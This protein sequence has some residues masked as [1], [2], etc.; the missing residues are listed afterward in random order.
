MAR[1]K[2]KKTYE[3]EELNIEEK[4]EGKDKLEKKHADDDE[5]EIKL[6]FF[7]KK[8]SSDSSRKKHDSDDEFIEFDFDKLSSLVSANKKLL[9]FLT[10]SSIFLFAL[11]TRLLP[12]TSGMLH[13]YDPYFWYRYAKL[14][15]QNGLHFPS[16][17]PYSYYPPGR[18]FETSTWFPA[19]QA[20]LYLFLK[21]LIPSITLMQTAKLLPA[22]YGSL[23]VI[24]AYFIGKKV[25]SEYAG[26]FSAFLIG[27]SPAIFG[28][29]LA[30]FGDTDGVV[31]FYSLLVIAFY[32]YM[33]ESLENK[34]ITKTT[35][36]YFAA[37][38]IA[39]VIFSMNWQMAVYITY[40]LFTF[41]FGLMLFY[42][43]F[44][45][46]KNFKRV[47]DSMKKAKNVTLLT[48]GFILSN[49]L[50]V[51]IIKFGLIP[52]FKGFLSNIRALLITMSSYSNTVTGLKGEGAGVGAYN[53]FISVAEMQA[54]Q[55]S[56]Y[57]SQLGN[58]MYLALFLFTIGTALIAF[59]FSRKE[60]SEMA[61]YAVTGI[62]L[63]LA[64][65][66]YASEILISILLVKLLIPLAAIF[67]MISLS[68]KQDFLIN[69]SNVFFEDERHLRGMLLILMW[70]GLLFAISTLGIRF[71]MVLSPAICVAAGVFIDKIIKVSEKLSKQL[72]PI[73]LLIFAIFIVATYAPIAINIGNSSGPSMTSE[74]HDSLTWIKEN[75]PQE[76]TTISWWDPGHWV[77]AITQRYSGADGA[78]CMG[79]LRPISN[80]IDDFGYMFATTNE[81]ES[82]ERMS[83]YK[84][85]ASELYLIS[86]ADLMGKFTW[87]SFF[88]SGQSQN[89]IMLNKNGEQPAENSTFHIYP[90]NPQTALIVSQEENGMMRPFLAEGNN[91]QP[92]REIAFVSENQ[93]MRADLQEGLEAMVWVAPNFGQVIF[94]PG[95]LKDNILTRTLLFQGQG[96]EHFELVYQTPQ[97][98]LYRI[99]L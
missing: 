84:G 18:V 8:K 3:G 92:I 5:F 91:L 97:I 27:T 49:Y 82:L 54:P 85:N 9:V 11:W 38:V 86:S 57:T 88:S 41:P 23:S 4:H 89:Y 74:W 13:A 78:H 64:I 73:V 98:K 12:G 10:L 67:F 76:T 87:L 30:G 63:A 31:V 29:T 47:T 62:F 90:I 35:W 39:S 45:Q 1:K 65:A 53:V 46:G 60:D 79:C 52:G 61:G 15:L 14:F 17:D 20:V 33:I 99:H 25:A 51:P 96:L 48:F 77:T 43:I 37:T 80:R 28:R 34:K 93:L 26:L 69:V 94:M 42:F 55:W 56:S 44:G 70:G 24:P 95:T 81:T 22:L 40:V 36:F 50:L 19:T 16:F 83:Y 2:R 7:K 68:N 32:L 71:I 72:A 75:T 21:G 59:R 66:A 58:I 6:P